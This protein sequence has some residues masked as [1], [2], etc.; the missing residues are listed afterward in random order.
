M[1]EMNNIVSQAAKFIL[2]ISIQLLI[3]NNIELFG[4]SSPYIY[5]LF[6]ITFPLEA[7]RNLLIFLGFLLGLCM[8]IWSNSGGIHAG[9]CVLIAYLRPYLLKFSFG[10]S[11]EYHNINIAKAEFK[12]QM[13][14]L[15]SIIFIH[16]FTLFALENFSTALLL[17]TLKSSLI[18][19]IFSS[20]LIYCII[21]IFSKT[22]K[23]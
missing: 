17:H 18:T 9:A 1:I 11:Y 3:V 20:T 10:I 16:H 7:N 13:L 5:I 15:L 19:G 23:K 4:Y 6:I 8:D 12:K 14:Y 22:S 21:I 2:L